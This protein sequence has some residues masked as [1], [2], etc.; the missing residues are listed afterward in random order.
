M[1]HGVNKIKFKSG[2]DANR[3]LMRKLLVNFITRGKITTTI[4]KVKLLKSDVDRIV[5]KAKNN[6]EANKNRMLRMLGSGQLLPNIFKEV[7]QPLKDKIG[8]YTRIVRLGVRETD[9]SQTARLEWAYP[10]VT[11]A[12]KPKKV[13]KNLTASGQEDKVK[14]KNK[15]KS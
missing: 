5:E 14:I 9:G 11:E 10:I 15:I 1:R 12:A 8:G 6:N 7:G 2:R 13:E 3:M 4:K